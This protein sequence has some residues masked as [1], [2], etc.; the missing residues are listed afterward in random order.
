MCLTLTGVCTSLS[1]VGGCL[2]GSGVVDR[3]RLFGSG[4]ID[5][6]RGGVDSWKYYACCRICL[7]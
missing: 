5:R 1:K 2:C 4:V 7:S 6:D 3:D